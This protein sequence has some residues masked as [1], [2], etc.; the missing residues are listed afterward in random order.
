[1]LDTPSKKG[2]GRPRIQAAPGAHTPSKKKGSEESGFAKKKSKLPGLVVTPGLKRG[3]SHGSK[4]WAH[5]KRNIVLLKTI[6]QDWD[7]EEEEMEEELGGEEE[8]EEGT[9]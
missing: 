9:D 7:A 6:I 5:Y 2:R 1:M 3:P 4:K 8:E